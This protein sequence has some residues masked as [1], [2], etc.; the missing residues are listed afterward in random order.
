[1]PRFPS[2]GN[3][4]NSHNDITSCSLPL[5]IFFLY[6][7]STFRNLIPLGKFSTSTHFLLSPS[8]FVFSSGIQSPFQDSV[9]CRNIFSF[10]PQFF[11]LLCDRSPH[12]P[13][14]FFIHSSVLFLILPTI[15]SSSSLHYFHSFLSSFLLILSRITSSAFFIFSFIPQFF[16]LIISTIPFTFL[17]ST[18]NLF[19]LYSSS[20][21][22][23]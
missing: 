11:S 5:L 8:M 6:S 22:T 13:R 20:S 15:A 21:F 16:S 17:P 2:D 1:M 23:F 10:I 7:Q 9:Y 3:Q 4:G 12:F 19:L 18:S 14:Y